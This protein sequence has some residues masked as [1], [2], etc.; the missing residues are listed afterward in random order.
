[1]EYL[2][3]RRIKMLSVMVVAYVITGFG[4]TALAQACKT[5]DAA[6][7]T[8]TTTYVAKRYHI[9]NPTMLSLSGYAKVGDSCFWALHF[10]VTD[11]KRNISLYLSPDQKYLTP[12]IYDLQDDPLVEERSVANTTMKSLVAGD[13]P[14]RGATNAK[15]R[16]VEFA[17]FECPY[18]KRMKDMLDQEMKTDS[19]ISVVFRNNPLSMHPWAKAAAQIA[20]CVQLQSPA[21]F[22]KVHD[23]FFDNQQAVTTSNI[24]D[25]STQFISAHTS[26]DQKLYQSCIA[27]DL[28]LGPVM[29]DSD[30]G[31][32]FGVRGTPTLFINGFMVPAIS[33]GTQLHSV[34]QAIE[35]GGSPLD[36]TLPAASSG[37]PILA[38]GQC[39]PIK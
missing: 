27:R 29:Q 34:I 1:M 24:S 4:P 9:Q 8:S 10:Q 15:V 26:I 19:T 39:A 12:A 30:L 13:P 17:D 37:A 31:Q 32:K 18:C 25:L 14:E 7:L 20:E 35:Q 11:T 33:S 21:D 16:I 28:A 3:A 6:T 38:G 36:V 22:W 2:F 5:P 23:F